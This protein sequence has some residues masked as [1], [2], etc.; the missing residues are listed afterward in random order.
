M[1]TP[2]ENG[3]AAMPV[4]QLLDPMDEYYGQTYYN[5]V[6]DD[7]I[8]G[9]Y[10]AWEYINNTTSQ[11]VCSLNHCPPTDVDFT[12]QTT[13]SSSYGLMQTMWSTTF[14]FGANWNNGN[15]GDPHE[16]FS[17]RLNVRLASRVIIY[18]F[19]R[20]EWDGRYATYNDAVDSTLRDYNNSTYYITAVRHWLPDFQIKWI[21]VR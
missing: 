21:D 15:A 7:D 14:V 17:P 5:N 1:G 2:V 16:L 10:S 18:H 4:G 19:N 8:N 11:W 6:V 9:Y 12:A 13:I 20:T 3:H